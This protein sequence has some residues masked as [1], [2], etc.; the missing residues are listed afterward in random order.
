VH[1]KYYDMNVLWSRGLAP[2]ILDLGAAQSCVV[3]FTSRRFYP[4]GKISDHIG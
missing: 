3:N 2:Q 1:Y 4:R